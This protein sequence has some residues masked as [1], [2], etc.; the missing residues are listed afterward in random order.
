MDEQASLQ[1]RTD[2]QSE[3]APLKFSV[4]LN[5]FDT[6][7]QAIQFSEWLGGYVREISRYI[8]L[9]QLDGITIAHD[10]RQ[11][12][13]DLDKG[14]ISSTPLTPSDGHAIGVAMTPSVM[15]GTSLKSHIVLNAAFMLELEN[16]KHE[17]F[18]LALHILAHECAHVEITHRFNTAFPGVLLQQA[19]ENLQKSYRWQIILACWDEYAAT[20]KSAPF[21]QVQTEGY[22]D[23]FLQHLD[24]AKLKAN[25]L[26]TAYRNHGSVV[27]I[28][29]EVYGVYGELLKFAAY[30]LGNM[31]GLGLNLDDVPRTKKALDGHWFTP[32]FEELS[33]ACEGI[34]ENYGEWTDQAA[35]EV[36]GDLADKLVA[37]GGV[38]VTTNANDQLYVDIPIT[39]ETVSD[40]ATSLANTK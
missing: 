32:Y 17:N 10:Y 4:N 33:V 27:Q 6:E 38:Y 19:Y 20:S 26:I 24:E 13:L 21:G 11:A 40:V 7:E 8:D 35:F 23:T 9:S 28:L 31:K 34:A 29:G 30:H 15:R 16:S 37:E 1:S 12:L 3:T 14:Y 18:G 39:P 2:N 25:C 5:G 36:I 22:E